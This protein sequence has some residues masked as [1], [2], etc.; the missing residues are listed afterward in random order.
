MAVFADRFLALLAAAVLPGTGRE[1]L[2]SLAVDPDPAGL[3]YAV[4]L[5]DGTV[6]GHCAQFEEELI[7]FMNAAVSVVRGPGSLAY[8]I[9]AAG[10][11]TLERAGAILEARVAAAAAEPG[12]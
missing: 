1:S 8:E 11:V 6:V 2:L 3:G 10:A 9:E 5:D 12:P 7:D 4:R